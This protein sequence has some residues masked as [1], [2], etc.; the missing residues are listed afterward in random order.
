MPF[1]SL[2]RLSDTELASAYHAG[3]ITFADARAEFDRREANERRAATIRARQSAWHDAAHAQYLMACAATN[4]YLLSRAGQ[5]AHGTP[6]L[7]TE[8]DLWRC[9][10]R[11]AERYA[12]EELREFWYHSPRITPAQYA[13]EIAASKRDEYATARAERAPVPATADLAADLAAN[14]AAR[15]EAVTIARPARPRVRAASSADLAAELAASIA[16]R[17]VTVPAPGSIARYTQALNSYAA[18]A[19]SLAARIAA[20]NARLVRQ[21]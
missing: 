2:R 21:T 5:A 11:D 17:P 12:S 8:F 10:E 7:R 18:M 6:R 9:S 1:T 20:S 4:G 15:R 3:V 14:V 13:R 16:A 19:E